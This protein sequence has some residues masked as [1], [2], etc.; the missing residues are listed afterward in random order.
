MR[1]AYFIYNPNIRQLQ[2]SNCRVR[3]YCIIR[4]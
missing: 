4:I 1:V 2:S 3:N